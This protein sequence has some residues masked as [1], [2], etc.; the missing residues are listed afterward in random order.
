[1]G[2]DAFEEVVALGDVPAYVE[3]VTEGVDARLGALMNAPICGVK[4]PFRPRKKIPKEYAVVFS[5]KA[6]N[7]RSMIQ[8]NWSRLPWTSIRY[9]YDA[10]AETGEYWKDLRPHPLR[11]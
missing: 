5:E 3:V 1:M 6:M 11:F 4:R 2:Y 8:P 10:N 9:H 7:R